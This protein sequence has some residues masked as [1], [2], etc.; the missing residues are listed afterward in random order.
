MS[1]YFDYFCKNIE[2]EE[3]RESEQITGTCYSMCPEDEVKL[4]ESSK[5]VHVLE[6]LGDERKL[7][8]SYCRSA[9][10]SHMAVPHLLRPYNILK[11]T[12]HYLLL[13][14]TRRVDVPQ[15]VVYDFVNDRLR[16]V[17]QDMTIQRLPPDECVQLM[18]PMVR[19][20]VYY[21]YVL[22]ELP[23]KDYDPVLN[24]K[25]LLECTKLCL[26]NCDNITERSDR[27]VIDRLTN[28]L[29]NMD[30]TSPKI[31][32]ACD[33]VLM[34]SLY[35]LCNLDNV[36]PLYRH[37]NLAK[38]LIREPTLQ[39]AYEIAIAN[40]QGNFVKV[41]RL[42]DKLCP[43]TYCAVYCYLPM[44]QRHGLQVLS[45][46]YHNKRLTVPSGVVTRWLKFPDQRQ[47]ENTCKDYGL[48]V[49]EGNVRFDKS[50]FQVEANLHKLKTQDLKTKFNM[51]IL[52]IFT[53][54]TKK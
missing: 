43:L 34:E 47:A 38:D 45:H 46:A 39:L 35:I 2:H 24:K 51:N 4:R 32:L 19:F 23:L 33:R 8:K 11:Q 28:F 26:N 9:A 16:A 21:G 3:V 49:E 42:M 13:E 29:S 12:V 37:F 36:H 44:L 52:D 5:L 50:E 22:S 15:S 25:I 17:R 7:V 6:V 1:S 31:E 54:T 14:V 41:C 53:Y 48:T 18:E 30:V 40:F 10:D 27:D 20:Y